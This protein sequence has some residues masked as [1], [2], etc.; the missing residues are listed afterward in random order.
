MGLLEEK[1]YYSATFSMTVPCPMF[2]ESEYEMVWMVYLAAAACGWLVW[3]KIT[4]FIPWWFIREPLWLMM[5]V[6]LFTP[7]RVAPM[8]VAQAPATIILLFDTV[9]GSGDDQARMLG[10]LSLV[11]GLVLG[12]Y[13]VFALLR[14]AWIQ[15][16]PIETKYARGQH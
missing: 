12:A 14:A 11:M 4:S 1:S 5:A 7:V 3:W 8:E 6:L 13:I 9:L 10:D 15:W 16:R 2:N